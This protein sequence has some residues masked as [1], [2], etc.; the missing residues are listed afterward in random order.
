MSPLNTEQ[1]VVLADPNFV[2]D[3]MPESAQ[4]DWDAMMRVNSD[5]LSAIP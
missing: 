5:I 4:V 3:A 2:W 1:E